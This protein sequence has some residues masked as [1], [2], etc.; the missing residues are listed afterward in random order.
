MDP[1]IAGSVGA[2]L[3]CLYRFQHLERERPGSRRSAAARLRRPAV[4]WAAASAILGGAGVCF[5]AGCAFVA[6]ARPHPVAATLYLATC[7]A[8]LVLILVLEALTFAYRLQFHREAEKRRRRAWRRTLMRAGP[9]SEAP[10]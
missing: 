7:A 2:A 8:M 3:W 9:A 4:A 6:M 1:G 10:L 5:L